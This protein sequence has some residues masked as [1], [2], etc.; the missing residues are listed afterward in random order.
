MKLLTGL[1]QAHALEWGNK[2]ASFVAMTQFLTVNGYDLTIEDTM[3]WPDQVIAPVQHRIT[4]EDLV[5][6]IRPF[7]VDASLVR[8]LKPRAQGRRP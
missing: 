6:A 4:E 5:R 8:G 2:G 7:V 3:T 1:A